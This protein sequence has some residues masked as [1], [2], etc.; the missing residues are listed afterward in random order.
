MQA[1]CNAGIAFLLMG[2]FAIG[3]PAWWLPGAVADEPSA[4]KVKMPERE[5]R[6][7]LQ[8]YQAS[9]SARSV[10]QY[11]QVIT[12]C[13][14][15]ASP[16][17]PQP[18]LQYSHQL[19]AWA[20]NS[21]GE[22]LTDLATDGLAA[23]AQS[24]AA[25]Q[26][27]LTAAAAEARAHALN[28]YQ[29]AVK[30]DATVWKHWHNQGVGSALA[31]DLAAAQRSFTRALALHKTYANTWFNRAE[32]HYRLK[33][34]DQAVEDYT[35]VLQLN[36]ADMAAITG[37]GHAHYRQR[38]YEAA[39]ADYANAHRL[40]PLSALVAGY[41]ADCH[42]HL[43]HWSLAA[44][45]YEQSLSLDNKDVRKLQNLAWL[46]AVCPAKE[47]RNPARAIQLATAAAKI[48]PTDFRIQDTL[49]AAYASNGQFNDA[50]T[51]AGRAIKLGEKKAAQTEI[52]AMMQRLELYLRNKP[53]VKDPA[54]S[55]V[56]EKPAR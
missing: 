37:R 26:K 5:R 54:V 53:Y 17:L 34:Y 31:G 44:K 27:E 28:D 6:L 39:I 13:E 2:V 50:I 4:L 48:S 36:P 45:W 3:C 14:Q 33:A 7:I 20:H 47:V 29:Q 12:L 56:A 23:A 40:Q 18:A 41:R 22:A 35:A 1:L 51:A 32:V 55:K 9:T 15:A 49:A 10:E 43:A 52:R 46:L 42:Y 38:K 11:T 8:A 25:D 30:F 16:A 21:R 19:R 24:N